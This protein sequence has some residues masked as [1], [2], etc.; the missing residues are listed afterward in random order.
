MSQVAVRLLGPF[1]LA[2][3][4]GPQRLPGL[5]ERALLAVQGV[6]LSHLLGYGVAEPGHAAVF[7]GLVP[8]ATVTEAPRLTRC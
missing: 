2:T 7:L 4:E 6:H 8:D 1:E 5:G 3:A